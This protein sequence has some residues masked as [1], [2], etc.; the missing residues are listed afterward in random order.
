MEKEF[1]CVTDLV[2]ERIKSGSIPGRR[3][4]PYKIGL[5]VE[6]GGMR[7]VVPG[8][9]IVGL[10]A[11]DALKAFDA[12]YAV[13]AG[14]AAVVYG[15]SG[16]APEGTGIY[17]QDINNS[18]FIDPRNLLKMKPAVNIP[19]LTH[20][21]MLETK[22]FDWE[23]VVGSPIPLHIYTTDAVNCQLV[24]LSEN[25]NTELQIADSLHYS[26]RIPVVA[27]MPVRVE[28]KY[29]TDGSALGD[30]IPLR[31]ALAD[32]CTHI[33]ALLSR[34]YGVNRTGMS[35]VDALGVAVLPWRFPK[36]AWHLFQKSRVYNR[37]LNSINMA[38]SGM[39][40]KARTIT[41][42]RIPS[43][44]PIISN[45]ETDAEKLRNGAIAGY[46]VVMNTF[47]KYSLPIDTEVAVI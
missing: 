20:H 40:S 46:E 21:V 39:D 25:L 8:G 7:G 23:K 26:S 27:G 36:L 32:N 34:P 45:L 15:I 13:S 17:Y 42:V 38:N 43:T 18:N 4:D 1:F 3:D 11:L 37:T 31:Q 6:G 19:F 30:G 41:G 14:A 9:E 47:K 29:Y 22:P 44:Y 28:D 16:K 5:V 24:D 35:P 33:L 10:Q 2:A 12:I